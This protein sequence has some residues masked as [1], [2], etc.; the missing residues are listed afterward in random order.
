MTV[1]DPIKQEMEKIEIPKE[2][3]ERS[4]RGIQQAKYEL[5]SGRNKAAKKVAKILGLTAASLVIAVT[6]GAATS[7]TFAEYVKSWFSFYKTDE[8][9]KKAV[10]AGFGEPIN[11]EVTDQGITFKVKEV[12]Q[13][14]LRISLLYSVEKD[15]K[16]VESD[17]LFDTFIPRGTDDDPYANRYEV[18]DTEGNVLPLRMEH[19]R[20]GNDRILILSLQSLAAGRG[21]SSIPELPHKII[22]RFDINQ[23]GDTR[24][25]WQLEVPLDLMKAKAATVVVPIN[26]RYT[27]PLGF[28]IDFHELR[29]GSST[30]EM[31]LQV[32]ET[33]AWR[34]AMKREPMFRYEVKDSEGNTVA[35]R[36][37]LNRKDL[38]LQS[39]NTIDRVFSGQGTLGHVEYRNSFVPFKDAKELSLF[40]TAIYLQEHLSTPIEVALPPKALLQKPLV[41]E[42]N[43]SKVTFKT[44]MKTEEQHESLKDGRTVFQGKGW[45]LE[46]DQQLGSSRLDLQWHLQSVLDRGSRF[47]TA[48]VLERDAE[49]NH[50]NRTM[51]FFADQ[52]SLPDSLSLQLMG[53]TKITPIDWSVPLVASSEPLPPMVDEL[54]YEMTVEQLEPELVNK[55]ERAIRELMPNQ[56]A[57]L[58]GAADYSDKWLL[59]TKDNSGSMAIVDKATAEPI[60]VQRTIP[61]YEL[62][63]SIQETVEEMLRKLH[64]EQPIRFKTANR[65][66]SIKD[67]HWLIQNE[68]ANMVIDAHTG[69]VD[70]AA[71]SYTAGKFDE[72]AKSAAEQ[73]FEQFSKGKSISFMEMK[74][75]WSPKQHVWEFYR[76]GSLLAQV[77]V[78]SNQVWLVQQSFKDDHPGDEAKARK[79]YANQSYTG[80]QAIAKVG[81]TIQ[82]VFGVAL[83]DYKVSVQLNEY[84]FSKKGSPSISGTVNARG[85][86]WRLE[87]LPFEG[88]QE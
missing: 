17:R 20:V 65:H 24:G 71:I 83:K 37:G 40:V 85:E 60:S 2:L 84:T 66:R 1:H 3:H 14:E 49:G 33:Q 53:G 58:Y 43:G 29:H 18:V 87:L 16:S 26:K 10:S 55:A 88:M 25:K 72:R 9:I 22:V 54:I 75:V 34:S 56:P 51:F 35:A 59:Y 63:K 30:S 19:T 4:I 7:P 57:E 64:P 69:N 50:R 31:V 13:D 44:R 73:A 82:Q 52:A 41:K 27:S 77:G 46:L 68:Q 39:V 74:R 38:G 70:S 86:F 61:Y 6:I 5:A 36:D 78:E 62:D 21:K 11:R 80:D 32:H 48:T 79:M 76:D 81:S 67:D 42:V 23:I 45:I 15:G 12:I 47:E 8:G 28:R